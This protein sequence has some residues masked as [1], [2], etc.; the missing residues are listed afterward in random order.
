[1]LGARVV[2]CEPNCRRLFRFQFISA[3]SL[4]VQP[5]SSLSALLEFVATVAVSR[6]NLSICLLD[7]NSKLLSFIALISSTSCRILPAQ[8]AE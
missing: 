1:M 3:L 4:S 8:N 7:C 5:S 2:Q 6:N